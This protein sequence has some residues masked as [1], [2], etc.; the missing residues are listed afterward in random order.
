MYILTSL[1][2]DKTSFYFSVFWIIF[3]IFLGLFLILFSPERLF[4]LSYSSA[5]ISA[6]LIVNNLPF[7]VSS[8]DS[9]NTFIYSIYLYV[10]FSLPSFSIAEYSTR[11]TFKE[12]D[13]KL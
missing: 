4:L 1:L 3:N 12:E 2:A 10:L 11:D 6:N 5:I 9:Y 8:H 7:T 13:P